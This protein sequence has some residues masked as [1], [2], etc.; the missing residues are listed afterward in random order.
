MSAA[1]K[2][3]DVPNVRR[4][5]SMSRAPKRWPILTVAAIPKPNAAPATRN[6]MMLALAV[7]ASASSPIS[8]PTQI[9]LTVPESDWRMLLSSIGTL[10]I[11]SVRR[12]GPSVRSPLKGLDGAL[13]I[14]PSRPARVAVELDVQSLGQSQIVVEAKSG[15]PAFAGVERGGVSALGHQVNALARD[16]VSRREREHFLDVGRLG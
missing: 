15:K 1:E 2:P 6:M 12:T 11:S 3:T 8:R 7:A 16:R 13:F 4:A 14:S 9:E 5:P 10:N